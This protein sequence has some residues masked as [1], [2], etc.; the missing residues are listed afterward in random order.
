MRH[1]DCGLGAFTASAFAACAPGQALDLEAVY[2][3]LL[4]QGD[5]ADYEVAGRFYEVG[6][7]NGLEETRE[8]FATR[9]TTP[10]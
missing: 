9:R 4:G 3:E 5:L 8:Y 2:Q 7:P 1:I 10:R 6:S